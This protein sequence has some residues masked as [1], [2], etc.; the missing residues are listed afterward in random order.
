MIP[1]TTTRIPGRAAGPDRPWP[2]ISFGDVG[3]V[4]NLAPSVAAIIGICRDLRA[5]VRES[6]FHPFFRYPFNHGNRVIKQ[7]Q[8]ETVLV[9]PTDSYP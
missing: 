3:D 2:T 1:P 9:D 6:F 5:H 7:S 4:S 8:L